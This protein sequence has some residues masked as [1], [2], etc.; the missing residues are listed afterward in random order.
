MIIKYSYRLVKL[1]KSRQIFKMHEQRHNSKQRALY[2]LQ[3]EKSS[4]RA[5]EIGG[6]TIRR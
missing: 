4:R 5:E 2:I 1:L 3:I 6:M